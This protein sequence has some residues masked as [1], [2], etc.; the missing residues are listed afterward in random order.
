M[1]DIQLD[2]L[3]ETN[4]QLLSLQNGIR[5]FKVLRRILI[6]GVQVKNTAKQSAGAL[7]IQLAQLEKICMTLTFLTSNF[8]E[9]KFCDLVTRNVQDEIVLWILLTIAGAGELKGSIH[10]IFRH[11]PIVTLCFYNQ[12]Q[13]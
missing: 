7:L 4:K 3:I 6:E 5:L 8:P 9:D 11:N 13:S 2:E 10:E 12:I 1:N